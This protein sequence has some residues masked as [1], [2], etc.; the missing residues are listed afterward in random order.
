M[1]K[2]QKDIYVII[3]DKSEIEYSESTMIVHGAKSR[4]KFYP[5]AQDLML[6]IKDRKWPI[7]NTFNTEQEN[8][9]LTGDICICLELIN[10]NEFGNLCRVLSSE[11]KSGWIREGCIVKIQKKIKLIET[12]ECLDY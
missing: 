1:E 6:A 11:G 7:F 4:I 2:Y 10:Y 3:L 5:T 9:F 8:M 12:C